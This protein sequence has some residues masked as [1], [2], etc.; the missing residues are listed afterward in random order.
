M[1]NKEIISKLEYVTTLT[2]QIGAFNL[3]QEDY[4]NDIDMDLKRDTKDPLIESL[5]ILRELR[6]TK[7]SH[8][9]LS[10]TIND[11]LREIDNILDNIVKQL[12]LG[13]EVK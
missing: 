2:E 12:N 5:L 13:K 3:L 1:N 9:L 4:I 6:R 7:S 10:Y 11:K 8:I